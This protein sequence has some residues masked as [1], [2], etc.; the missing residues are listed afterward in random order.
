MCSVI[1]KTIKVY[2]CVCVCVCVCIQ[3]ALRLLPVILHPTL[4]LILMCCSFILLNIKNTSCV[5]TTYI[6]ILLL[7]CS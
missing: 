3:Y 5:D 7:T 2:V 4:V 1:S 6:V